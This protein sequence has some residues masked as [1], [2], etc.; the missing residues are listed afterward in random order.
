MKKYHLVSSRQS[1][2]AS[3]QYGHDT[4]CFIYNQDFAS[5]PE[6]IGDWR[7]AT[8]HFFLDFP[9]LQHIHSLGSLILGGSS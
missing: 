5:H 7:L 4:H 8:A 6:S 2:V 1:P 3:R 9:A